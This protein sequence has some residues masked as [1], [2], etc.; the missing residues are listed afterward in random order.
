VP[1]IDTLSLPSDEFDEFWLYEVLPA[2]V[3]WP[4]QL[5][6]AVPELFGCSNDGFWT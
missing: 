2:P 3:D 1:V 6:G 5:S 4:C